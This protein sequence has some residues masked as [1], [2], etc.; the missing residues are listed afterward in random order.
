IWCFLIPTNHNARSRSTQ[1]GPSPSSAAR[2]QTFL[3]SLAA[4]SAPARVHEIF[5][6]GH[7][8]CFVRCEENDK[9]SDVFRHQAVLDALRADD[10]GFALGRVP[11]LL[12]RRLHIAGHD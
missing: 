7:S 12:A 8:L 1:T 4:T 11:L 2:F 6:P 10:L 5:V 3:G 9:R